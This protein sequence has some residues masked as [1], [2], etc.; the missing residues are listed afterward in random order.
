MVG[1]MYAFTIPTKIDYSRIDSID[2]QWILPIDTTL[3]PDGNWAG[4]A[5]SPIIDAGVIYFGGLDGKLYAIVP[6]SS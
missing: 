4:V 3:M 6:L 5:S 1:G 2:L